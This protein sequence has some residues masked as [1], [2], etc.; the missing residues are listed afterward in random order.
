MAS[1]GKSN[2]SKLMSVLLSL[3]MVL[4][5]MSF[6]LPI[7]VKAEST[8]LWEED[9][10]FELGEGEEYYD[11]STL[12][13]D[14][15]ATIGDSDGDDTGTFYAR[16]NDATISW[17]DAATV[18]GPKV[19]F[20]DGKVAL[21]EAKNTG[22]GGSKAELVIPMTFEGAHPTTGY[23]VFEFDYYSDSPFVKNRS[24]EW[25][26]QDL[27]LFN[28]TGTRHYS[29]VG[30]STT[31]GIQDL[32]DSPVEPNDPNTDSSTWK[33]KEAYALSGFYDSFVAGTNKNNIRQ[34]S[35][36]AGKPVHM[37]IIY[38]L[39]NMK[40]MI[41]ATVD[42]VK[43]FR[44]DTWMNIPG[45]VIGKVSEATPPSIGYFINR[46]KLQ[47]SE[48]PIGGSGDSVATYDNFVYTHYTV[49]PEF[50]SSSVENGGTDVPVSGT[51]DLEFTEDID[52]ASINGISLKAG[53]VEE[54]ISVAMKGA[55]GVRVTYEGL[56]GNVDYTLTVPETVTSVA[57]LPI[58]AVE[59][60]TF[61]TE[62]T[63]PTVTSVT[64]ADN[65]SNQL[66]T[67]TPQVTFSEMVDEETID[68]ITLSSAEGNVTVENS[69][70]ADGKTVTL[71][72]SMGL[73]TDTTYTVTVPV[74]VK[75]LGGTALTEE[76]TSTF[77]TSMGG[78]VLWSEDFEDLTN[79]NVGQL[80][81]TWTGNTPHNPQSNSPVQHQIA[82]GGDWSLADT[83]YSSRI[84]FNNN[85]TLEKSQYAEWGDTAPT[86]NIPLDLSQETPTTGYLVFSY[87]Y[88]AN[89]LA[90]R[91]RNAVTIRD[92]VLECAGATKTYAEVSVSSNYG[93]QDLYAA[94]ATMTDATYFENIRTAG[95]ITGKTVRMQ[96]VY[97]IVGRK[98]MI[99]ATVDGEK[100]YNNNNWIDITDGMVGT[101]YA[102][103]GQYFINRLV[104][105]QDQV[106]VYQNG[107][108]SATYDN[109]MYVHYTTLPNF[110][111]HSIADTADVNVV[112]S[113]DL[114]FDSAVDPASI[115]AISINA[116][117]SDVDEEIELTL[118]NSK[119][120][121]V[122]YKGLENSANYVL[123]VPVTVTNK[124]GLPVSNPQNI[125][126][127][128][129]ADAAPEITA[130]TVTNGDTGVSVN[131]VLKLT[132]STALDPETVSNITM[133]KADDETNY[134]TDYII[135][136]NNA[137]VTLYH[138][139]LASNTQYT[140]NIPATV[141]SSAGI[142]ATDWIVF[143]TGTYNAD[144]SVWSQD[145]DAIDAL[146][147]DALDEY[148]AAN[149]SDW[150]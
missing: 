9:F 26:Y 100:S 84:I 124:A 143:T 36:L 75:S 42:G 54:D 35:D 16:A 101:E 73:D 7:K 133:K 67:V 121:T 4:S 70:S 14:W 149:H 48:A 72:P 11:I 130:S 96:I 107:F 58:S 146:S 126:F 33:Y 32:I 128:T 88:V 76:F 51:I 145:F 10:D 98:Y 43:S 120:V 135:S 111:S 104:L 94:D 71:T 25:S 117:N 41:C 22:H 87:D 125:E 93:I 89:T 74:T 136:E 127:T 57:G 99:S 147:G 116:E 27:T 83:E 134:I 95:D 45:T 85:V 79:D 115:S 13:P 65:S 86:L 19:S 131:K 150:T 52:E 77:R 62:E 8:V 56:S 103:G 78:T 97:D 132:F 80:R 28:H 15:V 122:T 24:N 92:L 12:R 102:Q 40:Y 39:E 1:L 144:G 23:T 110:V 29:R 105:R 47:A 90:T 31:N 21:K 37:Q 114:T 138:N 118:K 38:D 141:K 34:G 49:L 60:I 68:G 61:K 81:N 148:M 2:F 106:N 142:S 44:G 109:F 129:N 66:L 64:P 82:A 20:E 139:T 108:A 50:Y 3:I 30:I 5:T 55:D 91:N 69:L 18:H 123:K 137:V 113:V 46:V 63:V 119:T 112:G 17:S 140:I 6:T 53:D 59:T